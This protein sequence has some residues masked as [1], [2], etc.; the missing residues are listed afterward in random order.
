MFRIKEM[1][2]RAGLT[3][4][5]AAAALGVKP[6]TYGDWERET[7][8]INLKYAI[9]AADLFECSLDELAGREWH[10][11]SGYDLDR[12]ERTLVDAYRST[13]AR[14]KRAIMRNAIDEAGMEGQS[15]DGQV[16]SA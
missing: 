6:F 4:T 9:M 14:G 12:D 7:T 11:E 3:Q 10:D 2:V 15:S 5:Q 13:D 1:R 16:R 8:T